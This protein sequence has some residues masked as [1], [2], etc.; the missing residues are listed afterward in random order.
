MP[1]LDTGS[2][3]ISESLVISDYLDEKY[4]TPPLYPPCPELKQKQKTFVEIVSGLTKVYHNFVLG[5]EEMNLI[6]KFEELKPKIQL[7][8]KELENKGCKY[9][10]NILPLKILLYI[11][12]SIFWG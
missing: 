1:V 4:S 10:V 2:E 12:S 7:L 3:I 6:T 8:E 11:F 5:K 9:V